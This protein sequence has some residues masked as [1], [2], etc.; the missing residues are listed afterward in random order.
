MLSLLL[1]EDPRHCERKSAQNSSGDQSIEIL[2][3]MKAGRIFLCM[4]W[5]LRIRPQCVNKRMNKVYG[6]TEIV[7]VCAKSFLC[8]THQTCS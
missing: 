7:D 1:A 3:K 8:V 6:G 4:E 2:W 5:M